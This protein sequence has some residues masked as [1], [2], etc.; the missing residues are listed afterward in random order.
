MMA[1]FGRVPKLDEERRRRNVPDGPT[2]VTG[3]R[4]TNVEIPEA[5][6]KWNPIALR[7]YE[8]LGQS[9]Q[10]DFYEPSDWAEAFYIAEVMHINL[11]QGR[12]SSTLFDSVG[13]QSA[14]LMTTEGDRR[15]L[16]VE[17]ERGV[18]VHDEAAE[19]E[20]EYRKQ[21]G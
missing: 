16:R 21:L 5:D 15:R 6:P 1:Q 10:S 4:S 20:A 2:K 8:A 17:L 11:Q 19:A 18:D 3:A 14:R 12:F 7:W 13:R 9:G